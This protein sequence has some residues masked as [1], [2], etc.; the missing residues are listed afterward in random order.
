MKVLLWRVTEFKAV[1]RNAS[2]HTY[3]NYDP[4]CPARFPLQFAEH[5]HFW[6]FK[7]IP[8]FL[9]IPPSLT[10]PKGT[11]T[12]PPPSIMVTRSLRLHHLI[13]SSWAVEAV[14]LHLYPCRI[15]SELENALHNYLLFRQGQH[16]DSELHPLH[17]FPI[18]TLISIL[19]RWGRFNQITEAV[20]K[21]VA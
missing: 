4:R 19:K 15:E 14:R 6:T 7:S 13:N 20:K 8:T 3:Q 10:L 9:K 18:R 16:S 12:S 5:S 17:R 2:F 11:R 1:Q 21:Y